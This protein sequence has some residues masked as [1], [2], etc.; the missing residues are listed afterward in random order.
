MGMHTVGVLVLMMVVLIV[1]IG[2]LMLAV[3]SIGAHEVKDD[4]PS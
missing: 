3:R 4:H 1:G 2:G